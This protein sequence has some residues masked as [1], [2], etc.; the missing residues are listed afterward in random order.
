MVPADGAVAQ[1]DVG[2]LWLTLVQ[3]LDA[4]DGPAAEALF[5]RIWGAVAASS[6]DDA[7]LRILVTRIGLISYEVPAH[8]AQL[9]AMW[10]AQSAG[11]T[12]ARARPQAGA[13]L[14]A[15]LGP[16]DA[17]GDHRGIIQA[18]VARDDLELL[19]HV[20]GS[21]P[22]HGAA[23]IRAAIDPDWLALQA[24][25]G[26][27]QALFLAA[28]ALTAAGESPASR[29][30][31][32]RL[33]APDTPAAQA[34]HELINAR[35]ARVRG[36]S[37][38][39]IR[40]GRVRVALCVSGQLRGWRAALTTWQALLETTHEVRIFVHSWRQIGRKSASPSHL[41]RSFSGRV[42]A[43]LQRA[44]AL[45]SAAGNDAFLF[46]A[47]PRVIAWFDRGEEVGEED[48]RDVYGAD[49]A[50]L[51]DDTRPPD[52]TLSNPQKMYA[53]VERCF[54]LVQSSGIAFDI[55]ARIRPDKSFGPSDVFD[56]RA[57]AARSHAEQAIFTDLAP[58][59]HPW[60]DLIVGDQ[61]ACGI[62]SV[63]AA[64]SRTNAFTV[65]AHARQL[66]GFPPYYDGHRNFARTCLMTGVRMLGAPG[67]A[68]GRLIDPPGIAPTT[69]L[70]LIRQDIA[71]RAANPF[72]QR[73]LAA[74]EADAAVL[75]D[76]PVR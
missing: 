24:S 76:E 11:R 60:G 52:N 3:A 6:L 40:P 66:H 18:I 57:M 70:S 61:F 59:M 22:V 36:L 7:G 49:A 42:L 29:L 17:P 39:A 12:E 54:E 10:Q 33:P 19:R 67:L 14:D 15:M 1:D 23:M 16:D 26:N 30:S 58:E 46:Q 9:R 63:M 44:V 38:P 74:A 71:A 64:Y 35:T 2:S 34:V 41:Y 27:A 51:E 62:P 48:V 68:F 4:A 65:A 5:G 43:E 73:L 47:Y 31:R 53:K 32:L 69:L 37:L 56:W 75:G 72:D 8:W 13:L 45:S 21:H 25:S 20:T 55:V 28:V 50:V